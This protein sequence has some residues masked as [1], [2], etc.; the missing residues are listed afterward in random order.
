MEAGLAKYQLKSYNILK[1][2][3]QKILEYYDHIFEKY[4]FTNPRFYFNQIGEFTDEWY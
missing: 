2:N 4:S 1:L 3:P